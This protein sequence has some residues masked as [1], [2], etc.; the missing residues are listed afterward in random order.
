VRA[1]MVA[2][3]TAVAVL[4]TSAVIAQPLAGGRYLGTAAEG[5]PANLTMN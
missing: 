5:G 1:V 2:T 4:R 3:S